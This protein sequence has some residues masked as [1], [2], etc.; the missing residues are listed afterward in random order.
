M[1][2]FHLAKTL[3]AACASAERLLGISEYGPIERMWILSST[4]YG[5]SNVHVATEM[6]CSNF[7]PVRRLQR[8]FAVSLNP[9]FLSSPRISLVAPTNGGQ[10]A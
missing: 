7:C 2:H 5:A 8:H 10:I 1:P 3:A 4:M 9:A 6:S